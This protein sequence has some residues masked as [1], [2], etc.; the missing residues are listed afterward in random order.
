MF[1][2]SMS[3]YHGSL[4]CGGRTSDDGAGNGEG[5]SSEYVVDVAVAGARSFSSS[6]TRS[7]S[8]SS[9]VKRSQP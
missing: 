6:S 8:N 7:R 2:L 1:A 5:V 4:R 9:F 3:T